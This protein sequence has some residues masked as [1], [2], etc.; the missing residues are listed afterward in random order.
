MKLGDWEIED[1]VTF[2]YFVDV[3]VFILANAAVAFWMCLLA[4]RELK[5]NYVDLLR[6]TQYGFIFLWYLYSTWYFLCSIWYDHIDNTAYETMN[7]M[8][9]GLLQYYYIVNLS[10]W[11]LLMIHIKILHKLRN[12]MQFQECK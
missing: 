2:L 10:S 11:Y 4:W 6:M 5:E 1:A 7:E 12:G 8:F 9:E 3:I